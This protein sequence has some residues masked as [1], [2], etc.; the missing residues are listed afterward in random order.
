MI[1]KFASVTLWVNDFEKAIQFYRDI[2]GL[3]LLTAPGEIPQFEIGDGLL[4]LVKGKFNPPSDAFPP[5]FPQFSLEVDDLD[6]VIAQLKS[7]DYPISGNIE[8]RR[9]ALLIT[10]YD[11]DENLIELVELKK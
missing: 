9:D 1:K 6:K 7:R 3:E 10:L 5:D 11:P 4:V 2:L 8:D